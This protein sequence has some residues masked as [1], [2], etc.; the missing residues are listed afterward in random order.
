MPSWTKE[1]LANYEA[2]NSVSRTIPQPA[3][4]NEPLGAAERKDSNPTRRTII[5][6]SYRRRLLD[7][8]NIAVKYFID[9]LR[10]AKLITDDTTKHIDL[11]VFQE[12]VKTKQEERTEIE[13]L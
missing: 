11:K 3:V 2:R 10:Y 7:F 9:S 1:Q 12:K 6:G 4:R 5:V 8:D 13:I